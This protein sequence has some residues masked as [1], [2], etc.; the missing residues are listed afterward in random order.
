M[1]G[2]EED[3]GSRDEEVERLASRAQARTVDRDKI[4]RSCCGKGA[5]VEDRD[6]GV[7]I[8]RGAIEDEGLKGS[9]VEDGS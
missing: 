3:D 2:K 8:K 4:A 1:G 9:M 6:I 7:R 5:E